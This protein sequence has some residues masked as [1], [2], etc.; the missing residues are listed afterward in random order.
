M[1]DHRDTDT[2]FQRALR[3][4]SRLIILGFLAGRKTGYD[5]VELAD[6]LHESP[7]RLRYHLRVL[8]NADLVAHVNDPAH[9]IARP[10]QYIVV[11][12]S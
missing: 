3:H 9:G 7:S 10:R 11:A 1:D 6:T 8:Q 4:R 12:H 2:V 5:E